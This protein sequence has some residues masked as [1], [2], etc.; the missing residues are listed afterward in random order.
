[1]LTNQQQLLLNA[2]YRLS[3]ERRTEQGAPLSIV[4]KDIDYYQSK[5]GS[6]SLAQDLFIIAIH[7]IDS[8]YIKQKHDEIRRRNNKGK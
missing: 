6:C 2:F 1:V 7:A 8:E 5:N 4:D 3:Q